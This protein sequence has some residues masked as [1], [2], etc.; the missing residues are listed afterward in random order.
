MDASTGIS[1]VVISRNEGRELAR[2]VE[3]FDDT[4]PAGAEIIVIDA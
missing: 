3:N 1:V 2:T 4:L